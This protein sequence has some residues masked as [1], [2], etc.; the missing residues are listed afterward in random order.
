MAEILHQFRLVVYPIIYRV[1]APSQVVVWDFSHQQYDV[2]KCR[3][4]S[5]HIFW[6]DGWKMRPS[7]WED[8]FS[9]AF[10]VSF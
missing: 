6:G 2:Q 10:A 5:K 3:F 9:V 4:L 8:I 1:S 7:F